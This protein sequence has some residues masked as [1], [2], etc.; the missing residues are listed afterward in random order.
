[1]TCREFIEFLWRYT[2]GELPPEE[3]FEFD[4]H[5]AV[6]PECISYL[7]SYVQTVEM[8][9]LAY[10]DPESTLPDEVPED[11][12]KAILAARSKTRG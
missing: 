6:C 12:V 2:S 4:A 8:E 3:R 10:P 5:M 1:M 7:R 11:L 9:K